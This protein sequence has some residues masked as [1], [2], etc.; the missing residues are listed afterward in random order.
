MIRMNIRDAYK[1]V[2][3]I[4][5]GDKNASQLMNDWCVAMEDYK[6]IRELCIKDYQESN[7]DWKEVAVSKVFNITKNN[8]VRLDLC[9]KKLLEI[10]SEL[11]VKLSSIFG[12]TNFNVEFIIYHGLGNAAGWAENLGEKFIILLGVEKIVELDWDTRDKLLDL[13]VHEYAH[14][15]HEIVRE[16]TLLPY[17]EDKFRREVFHMYMEGFATYCENFANGRIN[18]TKEWYNKCV[19]NEPK[20]KSI[21]L[22]Q[23]YDK[24]KSNM[25]FFG[26]W[27][28][29]LGLAETGYFMGAKVI[30][31]LIENYSLI[32]IM[33]LD[34]ESIEKAVLSY[35]KS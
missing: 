12:E 22:N 21:F 20:L 30:E 27:D 31:K 1:N 2:R 11:E 32:E 13:I 17:E 7:I 19:E 34:Y 6:D 16:D 18:S 35:L 25:S 26:D 24:E 28:K 15:I 8:T 4:Y 29:V 3:K 23:L 5:Q 10:F 33:K 9:Y 14:V